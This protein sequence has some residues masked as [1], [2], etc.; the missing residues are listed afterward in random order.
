MQGGVRVQPD[1]LVIQHRRE[2][3]LPGGRPPPGR[4]RRF[5]T[6]FFA[7]DRKCVAAERSGIVGP[8][9]ELTELA[10]VGLDEARNLDLPRITRAVLDDLEI[11][12]KG[13]FATH[14]PI[15]FYFERYGKGFR[16][17]L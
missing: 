8:D 7:I 14:L 9:A 16:D 2:G 12:A 5:D 13:G 11:A 6:R 17:A 4:P 3:Q 1:Q 15:P 10:W